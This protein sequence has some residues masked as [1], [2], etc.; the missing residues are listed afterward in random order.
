[1]NISP[2][3]HCIRGLSKQSSRALFYAWERL[4]A[5]FGWK[6][7][8]SW[9]AMDSTKPQQIGYVQGQPGSKMVTERSDVWDFQCLETKWTKRSSALYQPTHPQIWH[10]TITPSY[11][12]VASRMMQFPW[13]LPWLL[14]LLRTL[15]LVSSRWIYWTCILACVRFSNRIG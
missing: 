9:N 10:T 6:Q 15:W 4:G 5:P 13:N 1:M 11:F 8:H 14:L 3:L 2:A 7:P 12:L